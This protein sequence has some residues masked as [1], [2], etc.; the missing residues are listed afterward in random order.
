MAL[1]LLG[2]AERALAVTP[3]L[4]DIVSFVEDERFLKSDPL[5]P[6][7]KSLLRLMF[8]ETENMT[9]YDIDVISGWA[10]GFYQGDIRCGVSPD[11]WQ[12]VDWLKNEGYTHFP[13]VINISGRRS[14]KGVLGAI[15]AARQNFA[16]LQMGDLQEYFGI[17]DGKEVYCYVTAT[18]QAQAKAYQF[19]DLKRIMEGAPCFQPHMIEH[20]DMRI[21]LQTDADLIREAQMRRAGIK[22]EKPV[23]SIYNL[24]ASANSAAARGGAAFGVIYDEMAHMIVGTDGP[25]TSNAVYNALSPSLLQMGKF[26]IT[27]VPTSPYTMIGK[28]YELYADGLQVNEDGTPAYP[29]MLVVQLPAWVPYEGWDDLEATQGRVFKGAFRSPEDA[30]DIQTRDPYVFKVEH[31]AQWA[32][33]VD[34]YLQTV[35]VDRMF[36]PVPM[37]DG[38]VRVTE[39]TEDGN[40]RW[41]YRG[42]ADPAKSGDNFAVAIGHTEQIPDATGELWDHVFID[43]MHVWDHEDYEDQLV[44]WIEI[45]QTLVDKI[46]Q[47]PNMGTFSYDQYGSFATIPQMKQRLRRSKSRTTVKEHVHTQANNKRMAEL[48][49]AAL[50]LGW[51]HSYKD[52]Y[53]PDGASLLELELKFLQLRNGKVDH[54]KIGPIKT[55]DLATCVMVVTES[56]LGDQLERLKSRERLGSTS[57]AVGAQGGYKSGTSDQSAA[58]QALGRN[59]TA[60]TS[61]GYGRMARNAG[62]M[63]RKGRG[64]G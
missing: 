35:V 11:I 49:R 17:A 57:L 21:T 39:K 63:P 18:T 56:L 25:R 20:S 5:Y 60:S 31:L 61:R 30:I 27:Y 41:I 44:P 14:G 19:A 26:G 29:K 54:Q 13:E 46:I 28:A 7:Q 10:E 22:I 8:L 48:F 6:K 58:R 15:I 4:P 12:R 24:A 38:T 32:E 64:W 40:L 55:N 33:V 2:F 43:W 3:D 51:I 37:G 53:G 1:D 47:F 36:H 16:L 52:D 34:A 50:G 45:E 9:A 62:T 59:T 42:H 23:V